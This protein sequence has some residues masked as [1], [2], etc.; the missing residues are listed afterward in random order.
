[1][2]YTQ[3]EI[4]AWLILEMAGRI[5]IDT[6]GKADY[7]DAG[8]KIIVLAEQIKA[9]RSV[10]AMEK[11]G[12][13][14]WSCNATFEA[15]HC[16]HEEET[17]KITAHEKGKPNPIL[18]QDATVSLCPSSWAPMTTMLEEKWEKEA[19]TIFHSKG[20]I[21]PT[22]IVA[23][24]AGYLAGRRKGQEEIDRLKSALKEAIHELECSG[25]CYDHPSLIQL[26]SVMEVK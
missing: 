25:Y 7:H 17:I 13:D 15:S 22:H 11:G 14:A 3:S 2:L 1:M 6:N 19:I 21:D 8:N 4:E 10:Y 5:A 20:F 24:K 12:G 26:R 16:H 23:F 18:E 9:E